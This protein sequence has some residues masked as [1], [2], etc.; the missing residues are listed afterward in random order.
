MR[1]QI[2][3]VISWLEINPG[4][5]PIEALIQS[6]VYVKP[7]LLSYRT[8]GL[9]AAKREYYNQR[10]LDG[11]GI[12]DILSDAWAKIINNYASEYAYRITNE[13]T[14]TTIREI[15][16]A[17][18]YGYE[19]TM[20]NNQL[21]AYIRKRVQNEIS[22]QR[23]TLIARTESTTAANLGKE[24]GAKTYFN[25]Q[26]IIGYK[27]YIGR[28]DGKERIDHLE[29]NDTLIPIDENFDFGGE[30]A[31]RPGAVSLSAAQRCNCRCVIQ[32]MSER[33]A[34]RY[35]DRNN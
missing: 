31:P 8:V 28:N 24:E 18:A 30:L 6:D 9:L 23:A 3:P 5:P 21:A 35:R 34:N 20:N 7:M 12:I 29:L 2:H 15:Q 33:A 10:N 16:N 4:L 11:K 14:Q 13:L 26:G 22:R 25:E 32:Y 27:L 17:L 19:Q 1:K